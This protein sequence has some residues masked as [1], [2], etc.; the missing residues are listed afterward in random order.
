[1]ANRIGKRAFALAIAFSQIIAIQCLVNSTIKD[2]QGRRKACDV[3]IGIDQTLWEQND[4]NITVLVQ[5]AK[6]HVRGL[7]KLFSEQVFIEDF[8]AYYFNLNR[9]EIV[10][11]S[12]EG[13]AF[14]ENYEKNCTE[15]REAY[16][17]VMMNF[18]AAVC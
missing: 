18:S 13:H 10:F 9:V 2:P 5:L 17:K 1:M 3:L 4:K 11:G 12:C 14:E 16:L 7:N 15:Q 8:N 6:D